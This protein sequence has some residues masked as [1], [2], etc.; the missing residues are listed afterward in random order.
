MSEDCLYLNVWTPAQ[1]PDEKLP[2]M[3]FFYG[4]AFREVAPFAPWRS[5]TGPPLQRKESSSL[6]Q[7]TGSA[8]SASL[9]IPILDNE[10]PHNASGNYG[11]LDQGGPAGSSGT[12]VRSAATRPG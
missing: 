9:H 1:S 3:V 10:S 2:V 5:I 6:R 12:S 8:L 4:G 11:I 7:I